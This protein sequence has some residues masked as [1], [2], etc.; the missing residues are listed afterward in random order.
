MDVNLHGVFN[1]QQ[2]GGRVVVERG[3][4]VIMN[5]DPPWRPSAAS[6]PRPLASDEGERS[7][8]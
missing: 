3:G 8:G 2:A 7:S 6:G 4:E 5:I 1:S